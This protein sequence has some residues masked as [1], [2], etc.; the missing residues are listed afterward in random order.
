MVYKEKYQV[1]N[2]T[3]HPLGGPCNLHVLFVQTVQPVIKEFMAQ[4]FQIILGVLRREVRKNSHGYLTIFRNFKLNI[5]WCK[6]FKDAMMCRFS[7]IWE[8]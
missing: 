5:N 2:P 7:F 8:M 3:D 6:S 4:S 1:R